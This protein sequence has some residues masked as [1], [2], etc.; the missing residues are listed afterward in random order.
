ME[1][2]DDRVRF[3]RALAL[4]SSNGVFTKEYVDTSKIIPTPF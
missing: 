3:L 1:T 2:A 4:T